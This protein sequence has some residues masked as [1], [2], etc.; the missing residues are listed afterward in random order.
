[1]TNFFR[2]CTIFLILLATTTAQAESLTGLYNEAEVLEKDG[3]YSEA[4]EAYEKVLKAQAK[5]EEAHLAR[6]KLSS[7]YLRLFRLQ[8]GVEK[9]R[10][11]AEQDPENFDAFF[12]WPMLMR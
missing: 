9:A 7:L 8:E 5:G 12:I 10:E 6:L 3:F 11:V 2:W 4:A 1:M